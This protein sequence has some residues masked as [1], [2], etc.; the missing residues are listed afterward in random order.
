MRGQ[1]VVVFKEWSGTNYWVKISGYGLRN[2]KISQVWESFFWLHCNR[3]KEV[4]QSVNMTK[5]VD[6]VTR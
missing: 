5:I 4:I 6:I 1:K 2:L 3:E